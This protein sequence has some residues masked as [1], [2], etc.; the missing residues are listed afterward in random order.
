MTYA[1]CS[2]SRSKGTAGA[3][4]R[5][6]AAALGRGRGGR[7]LH[8]LRHEEIHAR[9]RELARRRVPLV[10][11]ERPLALAEQGELGHQRRRTPKRRLEK[12][13]HVTEESLRGVGVVQI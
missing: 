9:A 3:C 4:A 7:A 5:A 12:G 11:H 6:L 1:S 10:E 13:V 8:L 2:A